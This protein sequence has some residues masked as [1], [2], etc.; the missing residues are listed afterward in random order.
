MN[1]LKVGEREIFD[2]IFRTYY[3]QLVG[4]CMRYVSDQDLASEIVQDMFVKLWIK[5]EELDISSS[6]KAYLYRA[7]RNHA[8]NH[9]NQLKIQGRYRE[10][11]G[12]QTYDSSNDPLEIL[13]ESDLENRIKQ[14]VLSLPERRRLVFEMSRHEGLKNKQIAEKLNISVKTVE[15]Q[16]TKALEYLRNVLREYLPVGLMFYITF[17][18]F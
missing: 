15:N 11:I 5:R 17:G 18:G 10:Y 14:A 16:M 4:F 7:T 12:F 3:D 8:L 6:L 13:Q 1:G 9:L 2:E